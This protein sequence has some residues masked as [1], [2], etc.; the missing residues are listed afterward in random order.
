MGLKLFSIKDWKNSYEIS[1]NNAARNYGKITEKI[2]NFEVECN[3]R[4]NKI[5]EI[6]KR[7]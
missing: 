3:V 5:K 6:I 1:A 7:K 4:Y 2:A